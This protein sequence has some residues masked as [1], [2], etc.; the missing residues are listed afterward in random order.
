MEWNIVFDPDFKIWFDRQEQEF[1]D[2]TFAVY[3]GGKQNNPSESS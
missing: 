3:Q 1:Q 2:E